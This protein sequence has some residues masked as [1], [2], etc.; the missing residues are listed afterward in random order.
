MGFGQG[1]LW[2]GGLGKGDPRYIWLGGDKT[3]AELSVESTFSPS[4]STRT[5]LALAPLSYAALL[6][7]LSSAVPHPR[8]CVKML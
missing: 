3:A 4:L 2:L 7:P 5:R 1:P 8:G 6:A